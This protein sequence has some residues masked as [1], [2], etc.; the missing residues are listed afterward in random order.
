MDRCPPGRSDVAHS[1]VLIAV[2]LWGVFAAEGEV[3]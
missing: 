1:R 2:T 3:H